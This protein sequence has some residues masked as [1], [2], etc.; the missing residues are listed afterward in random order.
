MELVLADA[1]GWVGSV[2]FAV[3]GLPQAWNCVK[4][5]TA[6][7][8][9]AGFLGLWMLGEVCYVASILMKY[10]WVNWMMFN[11]ISNIVSIVVIGY[12]AIQDSLKDRA[13]VTRDMVSGQLPPH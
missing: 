3:C 6:K 13:K 4:T 7:G 5:N 11:Y 2:A 9:S 8:I 12:Y 10:G 1:I